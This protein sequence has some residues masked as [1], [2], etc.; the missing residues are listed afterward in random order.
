MTY[1]KIPNYTDQLPAKYR[2]GS[3]KTNNQ[4]GMSALFRAIVVAPSGSGKT[5]LI[6]DLL[7][8]S[9]D[10]Y[11]HVSF[12]CRNPDQPLYDYLRDKLAGHISFYTLE[13]I[14]T[15]D[16]IPNRGLQLVIFDDLTADTKIQHQIISHYY[17]R[18]RHKKI[19][20]AFLAHSYFAIDKLIRMNSD[21][22]MILKANAKRDL[23][24]V[25]KDFPVPGVNDDTFWQAYEQATK[26]KGQFLFVNNGHLYMN[27]KGRFSFLSYEAP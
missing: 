5:T 13:E 16:S 7:K 18:G 2:G 1:E 22:V 8:R 6:F 15:L 17:I 4:T 9:P 24:L 14:P 21:Q 27:W 26:D 11:T 19:A 20:T 23:K 12:I 3:I 10:I 25:L